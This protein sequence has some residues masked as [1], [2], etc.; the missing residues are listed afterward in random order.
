MS[1]CGTFAGGGTGLFA[2]QYVIDAKMT[3]R[4]MRSR[5]LSSQKVSP[6]QNAEKARS[7]PAT[8]TFM[9]ACFTFLT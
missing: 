9:F 3:K 2:N 5:S 4:G 8:T 6:N 7:S 1:A